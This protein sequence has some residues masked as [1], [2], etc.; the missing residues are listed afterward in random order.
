MQA[1]IVMQVE[2]NVIVRHSERVEAPVGDSC[3][4]FHFKTVVSFGAFDLLM[5]AEEQE[6]CDCNEGQSGQREYQAVEPVSLP[7][8]LR[9]TSAKA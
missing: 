8:P 1:L 9:P 2:A 5:P 4:T 6:D 7:S 3:A